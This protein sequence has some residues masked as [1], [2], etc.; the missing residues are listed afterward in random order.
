MREE[1]LGLSDA[2]PTSTPSTSAWIMMPAVL[3]GLTLPP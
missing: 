1:A 3:P 2:P